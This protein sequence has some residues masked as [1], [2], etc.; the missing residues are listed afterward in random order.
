MQDSSDRS[1]RYG[2]AVRPRTSSLEGGEW[3]PSVSDLTGVHEVCFCYQ[4]DPADG[5]ELPFT[6][7]AGE[8]T[9]RPS[10]RHW[11]E[12]WPAPG[13]PRAQSMAL[14]PSAGWRTSAPTSLARRREPLD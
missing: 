10:S 12:D 1:P 6:T 13:L 2:C 3:A 8:L 14:S 11:V 5:T 7:T 9:E 4:V